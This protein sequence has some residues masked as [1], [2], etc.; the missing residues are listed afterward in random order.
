V[1]Q[2]ARIAGAGM[3]IAVDV[4]ESKLAK[5]KDSARRTLSTRRR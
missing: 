2:G 4:F 1:I 3:I 5:A